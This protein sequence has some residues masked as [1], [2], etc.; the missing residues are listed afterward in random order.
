VCRNS[1]RGPN[2]FDVDMTFGKVFV[3]PANRFWGESA[4]INI[5]ADF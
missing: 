1:F 2:F 4:H 3:L 5:R